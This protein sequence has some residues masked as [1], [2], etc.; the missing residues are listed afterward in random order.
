MDWLQKDAFRYLESDFLTYRSSFCLRQI[1]ICF[2]ASIKKNRAV[3]FTMPA[4]AAETNAL[5]LDLWTIHRTCAERL[6][7]EIES[8]DLF[9]DSRS[10]ALEK[11]ILYL[12]GTKFEANVDKTPFFGGGAWVR[13]YCPQ[14]WQKAM[15]I[16][17][18]INQ[19]FKKEG[20]IIHYSLLKNPN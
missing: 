19:Y 3:W 12:D 14:P 13:R 1:R 5:V 18:Q 7:W 2:L 15:E 4:F 17:R 10:K 16:V 6:R 20:I 9:M 11:G 8:S